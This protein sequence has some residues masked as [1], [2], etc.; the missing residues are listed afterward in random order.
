MRLSDFGV[1]DPATFNLL[2]DLLGEALANR[3][4]PRQPAEA[5]S[6]DGALLIRL[7]PSDERNGHAEIVTSDGVLRGP[8]CEITIWYA[9][10]APV[11]E[12]L[13]EPEPVG[14]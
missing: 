14:A 4:D 11:A 13:T 9:H 5:A 1:L 12:P 7:G 3:T 6:M 8:D 2:L 10:E